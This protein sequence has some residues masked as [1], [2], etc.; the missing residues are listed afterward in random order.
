MKKNIF[1]T[2]ITERDLVIHT[3]RTAM[4]ALHDQM[5][6]F[7][8][9]YQDLYPPG[10]KFNPRKFAQVKTELAQLRTKRINKPR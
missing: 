7:D 9:T 6:L 3:I 4:S 1:K 8:I 10:E 5:N 2:D